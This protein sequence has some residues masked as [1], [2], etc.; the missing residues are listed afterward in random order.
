MDKILII[1]NSKSNFAVDT[2]IFKSAL[3]STNTANILT[4]N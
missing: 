2:A 4:V 1:S 3:K